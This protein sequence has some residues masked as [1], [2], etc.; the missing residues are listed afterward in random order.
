M[1]AL[2]QILVGVLWW[3][4]LITAVDGAKFELVALRLLLL[5]LFE[6]FIELW[7]KSSLIVDIECYTL[8][9]GDRH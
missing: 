7:V 3:L 1:A 8:L 5:D 9:L 2:V 4:R 6:K